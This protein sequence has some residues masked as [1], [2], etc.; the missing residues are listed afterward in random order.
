MALG[1]FA[2]SSIVTAPSPAL[3]GTSCVVT[4][5][6]G[7]LFAVGP[8]VIWPSTV[9]PLS[10]NA[11]IVTITAI[12][13]DTLTI[14]RAVEGTAAVVIVAGF[15]IQQDVTAG[16]LALFARLASPALTGTPTAP[17]NATASDN[18]TQVA[19]DA[20]VQAAITASGSPT[21]ATTVTGPDAFGAAAVVGTGTTY[22]RADHN[23]GLPAAP[24]SVSPATTV[25]GPDAYGAA[26]VVGTGTLYARNDHDHGLPAAPAVSLTYQQSYITANVAVSSAWT[27]VTSITLVAGTYEVFGQITIQATA[28]S[29]SPI[30]FLS[31]GPNSASGTG[32]LIGGAGFYDGI[33]GFPEVTITGSK[34]LVISSTTTLYLNAYAGVAATVLSETQGTQGDASGIYA[35]KIG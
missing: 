8:A 9:T 30:Y 2:I 27:A 3:S 11:E 18:S 20:F 34:V 1:N 17:T 26:A 23:H 6:Q 31:I 24:A 28:S 29:A 5:G 35:V 25:T 10:T 16:Y 13:T 4:A 21:A 15:Q 7:S 22:A 14:T 19:T 12:A 32:S 33:T